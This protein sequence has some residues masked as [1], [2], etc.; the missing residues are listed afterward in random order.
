MRGEEGRVRMLNDKTGNDE[1]YTFDK[2]GKVEFTKRKIV[3]L[4]SCIITHVFPPR[5]HSFSQ[6]SGLIKMCV[7]CV[8]VCVSVTI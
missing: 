7:C 4:H 2:G 8:C 1:S 3:E 6:C 5:F